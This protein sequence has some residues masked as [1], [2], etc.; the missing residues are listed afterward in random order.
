V[1][2]IFFKSLYFKNSII[3][4]EMI[5]WLLRLIFIKNYNI[6]SMK[7]KVDRVQCIALRQLPTPALNSRHDDNASN[8]RVQA[9]D[10]VY[11]SR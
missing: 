10:P 7:I 9:L 3:K 8:V 11:F 4:I 5:I 1:K 2:K 6:K